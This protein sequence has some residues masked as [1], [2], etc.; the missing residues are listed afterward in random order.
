MLVFLRFLLVLCILGMYLRL[1]HVLNCLNLCC[2]HCYCYDLR[3][4]KVDP[5]DV[6]PEL[7]NGDHLVLSCCLDELC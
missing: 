1:V 6:D 7:V 5:W 3:H 4:L 2:L